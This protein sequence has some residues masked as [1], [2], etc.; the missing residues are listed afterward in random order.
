MIEAEVIL[1]LFGFVAFAAVKSAKEYL[2]WYCKCLSI[3][4]IKGYALFIAKGAVVYLA[5]AVAS[6]GLVSLQMYLNRPDVRAY[7][8]FSAR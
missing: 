5:I 6:Y 3:T 7:L 2:D 1:V 4:R 8:G